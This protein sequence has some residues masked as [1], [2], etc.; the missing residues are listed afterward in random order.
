MLFYRTGIRSRK[1]Y[2]RFVFHFIN[3]VVVQCWLLYQFDSDQMHVP[4]KE[5]VCPLEFKLNLASTLCISTT[6]MEVVPKK[7]GRPAD[8]DQMNDE[9]KQRITHQVEQRCRVPNCKCKTTVI[10]S[11]SGQST[12]YLCFKSDCNCFLKFH[13]Q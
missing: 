6:G 13:T 11:S 2:H 1:W 12:I 4:K 8:M 5:Q 10:C 9:K 3:M 7:T